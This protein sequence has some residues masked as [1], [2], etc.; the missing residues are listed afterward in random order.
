MQRREGGLGL[1]LLNTDKG[2][3]ISHEAINKRIG[4]KLLLKIT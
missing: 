4:G 2:I 1:Y 3:L